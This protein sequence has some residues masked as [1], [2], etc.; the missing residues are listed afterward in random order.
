MK[1]PDK[2]ENPKFKVAAVVSEQIWTR[3]ALSDGISRLLMILH[4]DNHCALKKVLVPGRQLLDDTA[5]RTGE[6]KVQSCCSCFRTNM[7]QTST[8]RW[9]SRLWMISHDDNRCALKKVLVPGGQLLDDTAG[10]T[11]KSKVQSCCS[12]FRTTMNQTNTIWWVSRLLM[13]LH[14]DDHRCAS[15]KVLVP[16]RQLLDDT[17]GQTGNPKFKVAAVVSEQI[18]TRQALSDGISRLLMILHDDNHCALK[19]VLVPGRQ[20]L[21]DT[22]GQTGKSKV[23]S[24]CS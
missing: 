22:A 9:V 12:C 10:Q 24:C 2:L 20:L 19:K 21:D 13:I 7:K 15:K 14:D 8:I 16:G 3:Q 17:A 18:W 6:S 4:D 11:G 5:G 23:Q 1:Q